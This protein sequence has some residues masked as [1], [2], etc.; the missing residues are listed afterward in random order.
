MDRIEE[1]KISILEEGMTKEAMDELA[2][3]VT[4]AKVRGGE[5]A[6]AEKR[7]KDI[8]WAAYDRGELEKTLTINGTKLQCSDAGKPKETV[9]PGHWQM[10]DVETLIETYGI[11]SLVSNGIIEWVPEVKT[12]SEGKKGG[13]SITLPK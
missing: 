8:W 6:D 5:C 9:T 13:V 11:E 12:T 3:I 7:I 2:S 10:G 4:R 1:L